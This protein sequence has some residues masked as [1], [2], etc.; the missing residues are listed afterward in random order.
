VFI[1]NL[2]VKTTHVLHC[3][4][5]FINH[6]YNTCRYDRIVE[7]TQDH[8]LYVED[9]AS[10]RSTLKRPSLAPVSKKDLLKRR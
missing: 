6:I 9:E 5:S 1:T 10:L 7:D 3:F 4:C 2:D 8:Y